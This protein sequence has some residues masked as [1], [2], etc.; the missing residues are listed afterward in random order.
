VRYT[1]FVEGMVTGTATAAYVGVT[2]GSSPF[3]A[4]DVDVS[5]GGQIAQYVT[6]ESCQLSPNLQQNIDVLFSAQFNPG[7]LGEPTLVQGEADFDST[8]TLV[9]IGVYDESEVLV[10]GFT[11]TSAPARTTPTPPSPS[12]RLWRCWVSARWASFVG[13]SIDPRIR[14]AGR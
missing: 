13:V 5:G 8:V 4:L 6:T 7:A 12:P 10:S 3:E 1:F 2:I 14:R 9:G 11:V